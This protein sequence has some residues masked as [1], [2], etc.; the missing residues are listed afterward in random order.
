G[1]TQC[2]SGG[3]VVL[4]VGFPDGVCFGMP[5]HRGDGVCVCVCVYVC[6]CVCVCVCVF[7]LPSPLLVVLSSRSSLVPFCE[8]RYV[9][10]THPCSSAVLTNHQPV[11]THTHTH[12]RC[13]HTHTH[14]TH[15]HTHCTHTY[16]HCKHTYTHTHIH[17]L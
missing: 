5:Q 13:A 17:A 14:C 11:N 15:T 1:V 10:G 6:V 7:S 3:H 2:G 9:A 8:S 12:T 4:C 16:T